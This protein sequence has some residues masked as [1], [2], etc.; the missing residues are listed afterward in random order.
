MLHIEAA[1]FKKI[2]PMTHSSHLLLK[3]NAHFLFTRTIRVIV[4]NNKNNVLYGMYTISTVSV[5]NL[6]EIFQ[7]KLLMVWIRKPA[8]AGPM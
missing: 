8:Y 4:N 1:G 2:R 5:Q 6:F 3:L 7:I